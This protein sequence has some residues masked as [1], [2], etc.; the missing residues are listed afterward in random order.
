MFTV[1]NSESLWTGFDQNEFSRIKNA[2][3]EAGI[4]FKGRTKSQ[5]NRGNARGRRGSFGVNMDS[6]YQYEV[7]VYRKDLER[8]KYVIR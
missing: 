8:A 6:A 1:F 7:L 5:L 4:P 2:L 3:Y